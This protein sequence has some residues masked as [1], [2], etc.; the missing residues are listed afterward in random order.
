MIRFF[1]LIFSLVPQIC[2]GQSSLQTCSWLGVK[3]NCTAQ[4]DYPDGSKYNGEFRN[5]IRHGWG[6]F[7]FTNGDQYSGMWRQDKRE[8]YGF[9]TF[10]DDKGSTY[11][12]SGLWRDGLKHGE[13]FVVPLFFGPKIIAQ[14]WENGKLANWFEAINEQLHLLDRNC[15]PDEYYP[16]QSRQLN[17]Q[18]EVEIALL[19]DHKKNVERFFISRSSGSRRLDQAALKIVKACL[20]DSTLDKPSLVRA[21][22]LQRVSFAIPTVTLNTAAVINTQARFNLAEVQQVKPNLK[23]ET[24]TPS[25]SCPAVGVKHECVGTI[26]TGAGSYLG[27]FRND[28]PHGSG[29]FVWNHGSVLVGQWLENKIHG[30]G[31]LYNADGSIRA[32]GIWENDKLV[33]RYPVDTKKFPFAM[34]AHLAKVSADGVSRAEVTDELLTSLQSTKQV[35]VNATNFRYL[36][37][38]R[39]SVKYDI[40]EKVLRIDETELKIRLSDE[41]AVK[42]Y[43]DSLCAVTV[44]ITRFDTDG[45]WK[46][47]ARSTTHWLSTRITIDGGVSYAIFVPKQ[48]IEITQEQ[49]FLPGTRLTVELVLDRPEIAGRPCDA[50]NFGHSREIGDLYKLWI[51]DSSRIAETKERQR[52]LAEANAQEQQSRPTHVASPK[53]PHALIIGNAAYPGSSRLDNPINDAKAI[54][55]KLRSMGFTVTVVTDAN[56]QRL[57]QAMSQFRKTASNADLSLLFYSGHGVQIFGTNYILPIDVDQSDAA[58]ATIQGVSLNS[59]VENFLPGKTKIVFLDACRDNPL[60]RSNDRSVSKGLAPISVA[61]GT[62]I[63]YATKDGQTASDGVGQKNSPFTKALLEHLSDPQD[64]AV[65]LRKVR[66]KVMTATGG[67]QQPWEYGSLTGGELVL[68]GVRR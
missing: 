57:V 6:V 68:S 59:V 16:R 4:V 2:W 8:G 65:I 17:E 46:F 61:Q 42:P 52:L 14:E 23:S 3:D 24:V 26:S 50:T 56:R 39:L 49:L 15:Q 43:R 10:K 36:F 54:E 62:L 55:Q 19:F 21:L 31:I 67:K 35:R 7:T 66:E 63:A 45:R 47:V 48:S 28:V 32:S 33:S 29:R 41:Q 1:V 58:Q 18:G 20:N 9:Q 13:G 12:Y 34:G 60:Q 5:D 30:E 53:N 40:R 37:D 25:A 51:E 22:V 27:E 44:G 11:R 38:E 64:I